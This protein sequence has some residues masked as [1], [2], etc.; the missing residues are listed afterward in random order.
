MLFKR[1]TK[2]QNLQHNVNYFPKYFREKATFTSASSASYSAMIA[3]AVHAFS[4][5]SGIAEEEMQ[6]V[7]QILCSLLEK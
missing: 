5:V 1:L 7:L 4:E 3:D 6:F 2:I